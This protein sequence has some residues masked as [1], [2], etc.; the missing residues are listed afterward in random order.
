MIEWDLQ[1]AR[2][3]MAIVFTDESEVGPELSPVEE[4]RLRVLLQRK[5]PLNS[6]HWYELNRLNQKMVRSVGFLTRRFKSV[7]PGTG[8]DENELE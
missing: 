4:E 1:A 5:V 2:T 8:R 6:I 7:W 3:F